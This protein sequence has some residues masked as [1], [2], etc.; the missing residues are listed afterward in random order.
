VWKVEIREDSGSD[1]WDGGGSRERCDN[2]MVGILMGQPM[3]TCEQPGLVLSLSSLATLALRVLKALCS[4]S[5]HC[6]G[7]PFFVRSCN[8]CASLE[9]PLMNR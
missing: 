3:S 7:T 9:N 6:Q 8:G 1:T 2:V 4:L 5:V